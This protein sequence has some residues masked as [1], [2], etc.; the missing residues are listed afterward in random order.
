M[1]VA[2]WSS[3]I[4]KRPSVHL[5]RPP[6]R[7]PRLGPGVLAVLQHLHAVDEDVTHA[8]RVLV[9]VL[10]R[11]PVGDGLRVKD[12]DIGEI[13]FAQQAAVI[14]PEVGRRQVAELGTAASSGSSFSSRT[15]LPSTRAKFP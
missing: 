8:H 11:R 3:A 2:V 6:Q 4:R 15:Y 5:P 1:P 10:V 14:Q 13:T 9:R 12:D 7:A